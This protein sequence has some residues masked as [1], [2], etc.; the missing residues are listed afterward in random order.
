MAPFSLVD[1]DDIILS[2]SVLRSLTILGVDLKNRWILVLGI[3]VSTG[4]G[5]LFYFLINTRSLLSFVAGG[6]VA[7]ATL[8]V[9]LI[10]KESRQH[11]ML[12]R[13][14]HLIETVESVKWLP[15]VVTKISTSVHL[16]RTRYPNSEAEVFAKRLLGDRV[17]EMKRLEIGHIWCEYEDIEILFGY[18]FTLDVE[19]VQNMISLYDSIYGLSVHLRNED[20]P[21]ILH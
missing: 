16:V 15:E 6:Q 20:I 1:V 4:S 8:L 12:M 19:D 13:Q 9:E 10:F 7:V 5:L 21:C 11:A 18:F 2:V 3:F 17:K 14:S